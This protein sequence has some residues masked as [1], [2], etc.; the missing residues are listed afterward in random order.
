MVMVLRKNFGWMLLSSLFALLLLSQQLI[1]Q[2]RVVTSQ[3]ENADRL[4]GNTSSN[5]VGTNI[6]N[7]GSKAAISAELV[8]RIR[9]AADLRLRWRLNEAESLWRE[10]LTRDANNREALI[11]LADIERTRLNYSQ[12]L[13]YLNRASSAP[14]ETQ[15]EDSQ[16]LV[17]FGSLYLT[18]EEPDKAA[19]YFVRARQVSTSYPG[20][21]VGEAGVALLKRNYSEA[22]KLLEELLQDDPNRVDAHIGLARVYLEENRNTLAAYE[23][24]RAL[25]LD[26]FNVDAMAAL[27]AVRIAEKKP[28]S[29]RKLAKAVLDLNPYNSGV[30]RLLSQYLNSKKGYQVRLSPEAQSAITRADNFKDAGN[31]QAAIAEYRQA[32]ALEPKA[33]KGWLGLGACEL[34]LNRYN[35]VVISADRALQLDPDNALAHLQLS[36]AHSGIHE[37]ARIQVGA[38]D[39]RSLYLNNQAMTTEGLADVFINYKAL[40]NAEKQVIEQA[41]APFSMFIKDLKRKSAKHYLLSI[42]KK[43]SEVSGYESLDNR[44]TFDGRFYASVRGVGGL[45]A[46]SGVEYLD[47]AMRGGFNT[48]AHEFAHQ[49]H[50][51]ALST[52]ICE[53]IKKLYQRAV[54]NDRVLDYYAAS[55]EWEY[56]AQGYEAYVS[57]FK[58]PSAGVIA[59][60][61]RQELQQMDPDLFNL[62]EELSGRKPAVGGQ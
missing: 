42:D 21:I 51:S 22:E 32:L 14:S 19:R 43:L 48:I 24:Q 61:T 23:A 30:R 54:K 4:S 45:V 18:L 5:S 29:V 56:F 44:M 40:S 8:R 39:W 3:Q 17:A 53:R 36:L 52:E 25:D 15:L 20:A 27:C 26:K 33:I 16:L 35:G 12:A 7:S 50:T 57:N 60:H 6:S 2:S 34:S 1:A 55:N 11:G 28:D 38:T 10:V 9:Q 47:A 13:T 62:L 59:R 46:V 58:R 31:Y 49:V 41:V 37:Q